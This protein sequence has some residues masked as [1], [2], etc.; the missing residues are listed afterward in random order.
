MHTSPYTRWRLWWISAAVFSS[1]TRNSMTAHWQRKHRCQPF[2]VI[3]LWSCEAS[4]WRH[5]S[6]KNYDNS[7]R[8]LPNGTQSFDV[9]ATYQTVLNRLML[10]SCQLCDVAHDFRY[11]PCYI[12]KV[13]MPYVQAFV[14]QRQSIQF[15]Q[16]TVFIHI[17]QSYNGRSYCR[18]F[19]S[20]LSHTT[21]KS[22]WNRQHVSADEEQ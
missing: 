12:N 5:T 10:Q 1:L 8:H 13:Q 20:N 19:F 21:Y 17:A 15:P 18:H 2:C 4:Y 11:D 7:W 9:A 14:F 6:L 3:C 16:T 22:R